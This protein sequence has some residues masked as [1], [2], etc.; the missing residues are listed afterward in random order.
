MATPGYPQ[1]MQQQ[2]PMMGG[3]PPGFPPRPIK[4]G[5]SRAVPVVVSAGLAV[6]VFCGLLFG[7]GTGDPTASAAPAK[8][9]NVHVTSEEPPAPPPKTAPPKTAA[10]ATGSGS[11]N[12]VAT[13]KGSGAGSATAMVG[14]GAGSGSAVAV[15]AVDTAKLTIEVEPAAAAAVAKIQI[16]GKDIT[17]TSIDLPADKKSV[18]VSVTATGF[19][20]VD[21]KVD[22]TGG[23]ETKL[24]L[25]LTKRATG[26]TSSPGFGGAST[27]G[28]HV[29]TAPPKP[30]KPSNNGIIDI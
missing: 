24:Q 13:A 8:G 19:H 21:K 28:N 18:K 5:V 3:P 23:S 27:G 1:Q 16:D 30:K 29:P 17:G 9:N 15:K 2:N 20:S 26:G 11:A 10:T 4:H 6:G 14:S 12:S 7:L 25:E 22:V